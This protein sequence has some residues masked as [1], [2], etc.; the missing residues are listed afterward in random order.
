M[1]HPINKRVE[2][3]ESI[4]NNLKAIKSKQTEDGELYFFRNSKLKNW[5]ETFSLQVNDYFKQI[6]GL[7][8]VSIKFI[9]PLRLTTQ[10]KK[11]LFDISLLSKFT[12]LKFYLFK[13]IL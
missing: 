2:F 11:C 7:P 8:N 13:L 6:S 5:D 1:G 3:E 9:K 10:A 4:Y 12:K